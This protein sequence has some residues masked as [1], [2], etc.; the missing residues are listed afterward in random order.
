MCFTD[1]PGNGYNNDNLVILPEWHFA[2][3]EAVLGPNSIMGIVTHMQS[4]V[5]EIKMADG[6]V[7]YQWYEI[8]KYYE[9]G[10]YVEVVGGE[11]KGQ[12]YFHPPLNQD[13]GSEN[14][15]DVKAPEPPSP[16]RSHWSR[17]PALAGQELQGSKPVLWTV[18]EITLAEH[19][20]D[21]L[22]DL[23]QVADSQQTLDIN[24]QWA[25]IVSY[26]SACN[27]CNVKRLQILSTLTLQANL[28]SG[29]TDIGHIYPFAA[30]TVILIMPCSPPI[31]K[32][33]NGLTYRLH[34]EYPPANYEALV[35][36]KKRAKDNAHLNAVLKGGLIIT[37]NNL[38]LVTNIGDSMKLCLSYRQ[39]YQCSALL[40]M[41]IL[42]VLASL[43]PSCPL[44]HHDD[45][46]Q[47]E[48]LINYCMFTRLLWLWEQ[49]LICYKPDLQMP[50]I[51]V[52][53]VERSL[54]EVELQCQLQQKASAMQ[55]HKVINYQSIYVERW[56][57]CS[58]VSNGTLYLNDDKMALGSTSVEISD[59]LEIFSFAMEEG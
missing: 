48:Q 58:L 16:E 28:L 1:V 35:P 7:W 6:P 30:H 32:L 53:Q 33:K 59:E 55:T 50:R 18:Q 8:V 3:G 21:S 20:H 49:F 52:L 51:H 40:T 15:W 31:P 22:I 54:T 47:M 34:E 10:D 17:H 13:L 9:L 5:V 14:T 25:Q 2:K 26:L 39:S 23:C 43:S 46:K 44:K 27:Y 12:R 45:D 4:T 56:Q 11:I 41:D 24:N 38:M 42:L 57:F 36:S 19:E 37:N 29:A